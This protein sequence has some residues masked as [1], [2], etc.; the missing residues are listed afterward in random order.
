MKDRADLDIILREVQKPGRYVGGEWNIIQKNPQKVKAKIALVFPDLYEIGMSYLG[1]KILYHILNRH[2]NYL[3]ERVFAPWIDFEEQLRTHEIPLYSLENRIPLHEFDLVGFSLLYE[4]NYSNILTILDLGRIPLMASDR[5]VQAPLICAGGPAAFNP[6]PVADYFDLFLIGDGEEAFLEI[7]DQY[8]ELRHHHQD[9]QELLK[10]L[11]K[12]SGTYIP[13]LYDTYV[14]AHSTLLAV[15]PGVGAPSKI[16]K[17]IL[18]QLDNAVFP[19][20]I[21]VPNIRVVFDRVSVEAERGC[22]QRCRFCQATSLYFPPRVKEPVH[23]TAT[24]LKSVQSTGYEDASLSALSISDYPYFDQTVRGLMGKLEEERVSLSVSSLRPKGL[25]SE[26]V[27]NILRVRKTGFTLVPEAGTERLRCVINKDVQDRDIWNAVDI[28]FSQGW[29]LLK[30]YFMVGLPTETEEDLEGIIHMVTEIVKRGYK[31]LGKNPQINLSISSFIPKPHTPFQWEKMDEDE[32]LTEKHRFIRSGLRK[33][34]FVKFKEHNR[35]SSMLEGVFS[36]GDRRL[37]NVLKDAWKKGARFDSWNELFKF[38]VWQDAFQ[39]NELNYRNF[40]S[41][42]DQKAVLPWDHIQTGIKKSHFQEE[43]SKALEQ[44]M[45]LNCLEREC[46]SCQGCILSPLLIK[47]FSAGDTPLL[48]DESTLVGEKTEDTNRYRLYYS[49]LGKIRYISHL[50]L[51]NMIQRTFRRAGVSVE[52]SQG[53]HPKMLMSYL[54]ALPLGMGGASEVLAFKSHH[55]LPNI[56]T[57][58]RLNRA[59][60]SGLEFHRLEWIDPDVPVLSE[61]LDS[62][63]YSL[64]LTSSVVKNALIE[65]RRS[66]DLSTKSDPETM[67]LMIEEYRPLSQD[68]ESVDMDVDEE[69]ARLFISVKYSPH[70]MARPQDIVKE[71]TGLAY[72][73]FDMTRECATFKPI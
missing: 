46:D 34:P 50:D 8:T 68:M 58:D 66:K 49:K 42:I 41:A 25:T 3:A 23:L 69:Q 60:P 51:V 65:F 54:P 4:L 39:T 9:R 22:P 36:R 52:Y 14:P 20:D 32:V 47:E 26:V 6:E 45:T 53:Y 38:S 44:K 10:Q 40:L 18:S 2:P 73:T 43:M 57:I 24:V 61:T 13:S 37:V 35:Y 33:Y 72:P 64:D 16:K 30:L 31:K 55:A 67:R 21:I 63:V 29:R 15:K 28:A 27:E 1:Q 17:R 71:I 70:K 7:V 19:E 5:D 12:V 56:E 62:F 48:K 11:A 59:S